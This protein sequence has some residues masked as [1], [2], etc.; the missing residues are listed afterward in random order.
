MP[1]AER[2]RLRSAAVCS[3]ISARDPPRSPATSRAAGAG[4]GS[5]GR[6]LPLLGGSSEAEETPTV[7]AEEATRPPTIMAEMRAW[8]DSWW[9]RCL[10]GDFM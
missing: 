9:A 1:G 3:L 7:A 6:G 10:P 8:P 4:E 2:A 5:A